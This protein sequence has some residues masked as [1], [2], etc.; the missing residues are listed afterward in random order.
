MIAVIHPDWCASERCDVG[1][2]VGA[3]HRSLPRVV[4]TDP[5]TRSSVVLLAVASNGGLVL[6]D[7]WT[8][9]GDES[10]RVMLTRSQLGHFRHLA[11]QLLDATRR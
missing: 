9:A 3:W 11:G 1:T 6:Y 5:L 8:G 4:H 2:V 10:L 7:L